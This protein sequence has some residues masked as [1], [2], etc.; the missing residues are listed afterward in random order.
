MTLKKATL[1]QLDVKGK[2][3]LIRVD[4]N[5][6]LKEGVITNNQRIVAALPTIQHCISN[7]AKSVV[8]MSHLGRPD[9]QVN[10]KYTLAP[11]AEELKKLLQRDVL[12]L[13]DC[14]GS[15]VESACSNAA[16]GEVI[17][18]EN[19][20]FHVEEEGKGVDK[21]GNKVKAEKEAIANFRESLSKLGEIYVNDAFGTAHR[22]H[23]SMVGISHKQRVAGFLMEKELKYFEKVLEN[24]DRPFLAILGGA[25]VADKIQLINNILDKVNE[26]IIGGGMAFTFLKV[27]NNMEIGASLYD[28]EGSKII[29]ELMETAKSKGVKIHLP[30]DFVCGSKFSNDAETCVATVKDGIRAGYMGLDV[31]PES[32]AQFGTVI[33]QSKLIFWNGPAG[34][35]EMPK[36]A[37]GTKGVMDKV[38][39]ATKRGVVTV[40]GGGDTAT[41][42]V[43]FGREKDVSH[44]STGGGASIELLEGKELP[45]VAFLSD[46]V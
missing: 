30:T 7:G 15:E 27:L 6:P 9:G 42:A 24:P 34:V 44:V 37:E 20:R 45:G 39:D 10:K 43:K 11:V 5:V 14:V 18:L 22:A 8:L 3:V 31:G 13:S 38:C 28:E 23:S 40:I 25:K 46:T 2:K 19:L 21:D 16:D 32:T 41:A 12:F 26:L 35:F 1:T 17:L 36:F 29:K 4:F 33:D